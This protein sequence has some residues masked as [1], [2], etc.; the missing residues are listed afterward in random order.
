[1]KKLG[2]AFAALITLAVL[3]LA[4]AGRSGIRIG[5]MSV[6]LSPDAHYVE[7]KTLD[8]MEDVRYKDFKKA[9]SYH[10]AAERKTVDIPN[11]IER[12][13]AIKPEFLDILRYQVSA[14]DLDRSGERARVH[15]KAV[16][17]V[18]NTK[19]IK[20]P[21]VIYYWFKDPSEGWC[22]RLESSLR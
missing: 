18:L 13:F 22:M 1:M 10:T 4:L 11:L 5:A 21:E 8:F 12:I 19:E 6:S 9:A 15:V 3:L 16:V 14:V 7:Q 17:K 2:L 20:E